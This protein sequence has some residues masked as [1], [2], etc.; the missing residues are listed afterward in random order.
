MPPKRN[1]G[2]AVQTLQ[3]GLGEGS[4]THSEGENEPIIPP[5]L[6]PIL[7]EHSFVNPTFNKGSKFGDD[8]AQ[9]G[10]SLVKAVSDQI[11]IMRH[12]LMESEEKARQRSQEVSIQ[13]DESFQNLAQNLAQSVAQSVA[14][15]R[16]SN[17]ESNRIWREQNA[18]N[19][20]AFQAETE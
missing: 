20:R 8:V 17:E 19:W 18:K 12:T 9:S 1:L 15:M 2:K 4:P 6:S 10:D 16:R 11:S 13:L 14:D 7:R 3:I 5:P